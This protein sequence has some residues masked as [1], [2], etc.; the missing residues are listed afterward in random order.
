MADDQ[1][2][3]PAFIRL[4]TQGN[5]FADFTRQ[6]DS[7]AADG[8][9]SMERHF[10]GSA[11]AISRVMQSALSRPLTQAG[12]L[13]LGVDSLRQTVAAAEATAAAYRTAAAAA[14]ALAARETEL[15]AAQQVVIARTREAADAAATDALKKREQLG[16][17]EALQAEM[18]ASARVAA[19]AGTANLNLAATHGV[20]RSGT[21]N[22]RLAQ[23]ELMHVVRA[24]AD[25]I[26]AG[27]NPVQVMAMEM[28][29]V[30]EAAAFSGGALGKV[31][32]FMQ[33]P[34][35]IAALA[36]ATVVGM[37]IAKFVS[38][39]GEAHKLGDELKKAA[40]AADSFG[41]TQNYLSKVMDLTTGKFIT[42]NMVLRETIRL[43]AEAA[44]LQGQKDEKEA[45]K[46]IGNIIPETE[47]AVEVSMAGGFGQRGDSVSAAQ[48]QL[49]V[50]HQMDRQNAPLARL[51]DDILGGSLSDVT[52]IRERVDTMVKAGQLA[53]F[54]A[55][56]IIKLKEALFSLPRSL[57]DQKAA[58]EAIDAVSGKG[59]AADLRQEKKGA[60][61]SGRIDSLQEYA[62]QARSQIEGIEGR[63]SDTPKIAQQAAAALNQLGLI[64]DQLTLKDKELKKLG[65]DGGLKDYAKLMALVGEAKENVKDGEIR[66]LGKDFE[67][68]PKAFQK[69]AQNLAELDRLTVVNAGNQERLVRIA[70]ERE[71]IETGLLRPLRD[72]LVAQ[73]RQAQ[74]QDA[75]NDGHEREAAFLQAKFALMDKLGAKD[76]EQLQRTLSLGKFQGDINELLREQIDLQHRQ[77]LA[78]QEL[79]AKLQPYM[80]ALQSMRDST[81]Q[82]IEDLLGGKGPKSLGDFATN[83]VTG[84]RKALAEQ[85]THGLVDGPLQDIREQLT[86][87]K[88]PL[89]KATSEAAA[90]MDQTKAALAQLTQSVGAAQPPVDTFSSTLTGATAA[91]E[92]FTATMGTAADR[93]ASGGGAGADVADGPTAADVLGTARRYVGLNETDNKGTLERLF[94][95]AGIHIDPEKTAWCAAFVN[96]VLAANG[97]RG[98][99]SLAA[100]SFLNYGTATDDPQPGDIVVFRHHVGFLAGF[101]P[102]GNPIVTGGNQGADGEVSTEGFPKSEVL[103][104]R[105]IP[106][107]AAALEALTPA[108]RA[109][110]DNITA[111]VETFSS[112][113]SV[114]E[115]A[116]DGISGFLTK[117]AN[118]LADGQDNFIEGP[119]VTG[120]RQPAGG[121][122][123]GMSLIETYERWG[124][125]V[126]AEIG[127]MLGNSDLGGS[128][129]G[130]IG[131][132]I[133]YYALAQ[134]LQ[135]GIEKVFGIKHNLLG[136]LF[137]VA[138]SLIG[139]ALGMN[140]PKQSG[141]TFSVDAYGNI[142]VAAG[143]GNDAA[144]RQQAL[145]E[146]QSVSSAIQS[147][148]KQ[149]G[150]NLVGSA[151]SGVTLGYRASDK[152]QPFRVDTTGAGRA[153]GNGVLA[154]A[155]EQEAVNKAIQLMIQRGVIGGISAASQKILQ[156]GQDLQ[157]AL[158]KAT[159]IE[160]LPKQL[161]KIT[162]PVGAALDDLN[163]QFTTLKKAL[164]EGGASADQYAQA[165][166]LYALQRQQAIDE[167]G[168]QMTGAFK[169]MLSDLTTNNTAFSLRDR[170]ASAQATLSPFEAEVRAGNYT[171]ASEFADAVRTVEG[172]M[173]QLD[174][175]QQ[176]YFDFVKTYTDLTTTALN[177]QQA[178]VDAATGAASPFAGF[179]PPVD[180][181]PAIDRLSD[182]VG[183]ILEGRIAG[184]LSAINDNVSS[185]VIQG[186]G[187]GGGGGLLVRRSNF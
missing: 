18:N 2:V 178:K 58:R 132:A 117:I 11:E 82:V 181:T 1:L 157:A 118:G 107:L 112:L 12:A 98:T 64:Q 68:A 153:T 20:L 148:V 141:S 43:Q 124:H 114:A 66:L 152:N 44:L 177:A 163:V 135:G 164:D 53:K 79:R 8:A 51:R 24:S 35:G 29:R 145:Q 34:W 113:G 87:W 32:A 13:D 122:G 144:S 156:S 146:A 134:T 115:K 86:G 33:G 93:A 55:D 171:H 84:F 108:T 19:L 46:K 150:G 160:S 139:N 155:T 95:G 116:G 41:N 39:E 21:N 5:A 176:G 30:G 6:A 49:D 119:V 76:E 36:A 149:I 106:G 169:Q 158:E 16:V 102:N 48:R 38:A 31:G 99:G 62:E 91:V 159:L 105:H 25:A 70:R 57:I 175:S 186:A 127:K 92:R 104:Y 40:D 110:N 71:I 109:A 90:T 37:L 52:A 167:A 173:R 80:D 42:H 100:K 73:D 184:I 78:A 179:T 162:D 27:A 185:L 172:I 83:L 96:A 120:P 183:G 128:I 10:R 130:A 72:Y 4:E 85:L 61:H 165:Q 137:G 54:S 140:A 89:K 168:K 59:L 14:D 7:A 166:Q 131:Q 74:V 123:A 138:G 142:T 9:A 170:L 154:F 103:A 69:A 75:L 97:I 77:A 81:R 161:K 94:G 47:G 129:G 45:R 63:F 133:P 174:G 88:D 126:G 28:G 121:A 187:G 23:Y 136:D 147:I 101:R 151:L 26:A 15:S 125:T 180:T 3:F 60:D 56:E 111:M 67:E 22:S 143:K 17:F 50:I 65:V 182:R